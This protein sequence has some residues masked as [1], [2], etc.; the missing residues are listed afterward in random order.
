M[1]QTKKLYVER[2]PNMTYGVKATHTDKP[3]VTAKTQ[4]A[5]IVKAKKLDPKEL[6]VERVRVTIRGSRDKWRKAS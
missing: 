4:A 5:A 2:L 6:L 3:I 1:K